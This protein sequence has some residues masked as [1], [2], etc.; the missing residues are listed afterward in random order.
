MKIC[1]FHLR[2]CGLDAERHSIIELA[3]IVEDTKNPLP[4]NE[5]PKF[6]TLVFNE[7]YHGDP[8]ALYMNSK[9]FEKI[10][11]LSK[12]NSHENI[13]TINMLAL[14]IYTWLAKHIDTFVNDSNYMNDFDSFG[15]S[16]NNEGVIQSNK[17]PKL[18]INA[19]GKNF[20]VFQ[21][22]FLK[23]IPN[24]NDYISINHRFLEPSILF[25]R[26]EDESLPNTEECKKRIGM[27][28]TNDNYYSATALQDCYDVITLFRKQLKY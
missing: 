1:I 9:V 16:Y 2:T 20:G 18:L 6:Q 3:I 15:K 26:N 28:S 17:K 13:L 27:E 14:N 8:T 21:H 12:N 22:R 10:A 24:F 5:L 19:G 25:F 4:Y 23:T 7:V 11:E